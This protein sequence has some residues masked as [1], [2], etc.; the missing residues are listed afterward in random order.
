MRIWLDL[1]LAA[2]LAAVHHDDFLFGLMRI[3]LDAA[4]A[5]LAGM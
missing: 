2:V 3:A 4:D 5:Q 1:G